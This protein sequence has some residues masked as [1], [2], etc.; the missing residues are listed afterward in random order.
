MC[1]ALKDPNSGVTYLAASAAGDGIADSG[2]FRLPCGEING[3]TGPKGHSRIFEHLLKRAEVG[4]DHG[5]TT[6]H[7]LRHN[8]AKD[9]S[10]K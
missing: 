3:I 9:F 4:S 6:Q 5:Q 7:I 8:H 10:T 1:R 2:L